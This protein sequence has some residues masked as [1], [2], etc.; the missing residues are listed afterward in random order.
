MANEPDPFRRYEGATVLPLPLGEEEPDGDY[1]DLYER[2]KNQFQPFTLR[3]ISKFLELSLGL[4][5]WKSYG[6]A[7]WALRMNPSSGN[8]HPTEAYVILV[9]SD[10]NHRG[11]VCH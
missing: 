3:N 1:R 4:S 7:K 2:G 9:L 8:L 6:G 10:S 11:G 5:A